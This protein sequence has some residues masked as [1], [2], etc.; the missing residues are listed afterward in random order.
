M[1]T[2]R[3]VVAL[4]LALGRG[5][6]LLQLGIEAGK[7]ADHLQADAVDVHLRHLALQRGDEEFHEEGNL[8]GGTP[9]V[10]RAE[11]EQGQVFD[12]AQGA[13]LD[14]VAYRLD[15]FDMAGNARQET[16]GSPA[17]VAIHDHGN[18]A[19]H[20]GSLGNP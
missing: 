20:R 3:R 15:P 6:H 9:P 2:V 5:D 14:H 1:V 12:A 4:G 17:A 8:I 18:V 11:S 19:R 7:I 16:L 13:G 10:F